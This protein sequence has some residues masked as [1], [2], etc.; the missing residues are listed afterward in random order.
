MAREWVAREQGKHVRLAGQEA[1]LNLYHPGILPP[2]A[3]RGKPQ[4]PVKAWLIGR[5]NPRRDMHVLRFIAEG[6]GRPGL[7]VARTLEFDFVSLARNDGKKTELVGEAERFQDANR[8]HRERRI[9]E[10]H[11]DEES[12]RRIENPSQENCL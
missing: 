10:H 1:F 8:A 2:I 7:A 6:V 9:W 3:Q 5:I 11:E 4:V 12:R